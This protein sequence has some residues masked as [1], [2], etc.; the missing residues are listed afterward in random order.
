MISRGEFLL[1]GLVTLTLIG[2]VYYLFRPNETEDDITPS[3]GGLQLEK[4]NILPPG[5][6]MF[7]PTSEWQPVGDDDICPTGLEYKLNVYEG[8]KFARVMPPE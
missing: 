4:S 2:M 8:T 7:I 1:N 6:K 3:E 5:K